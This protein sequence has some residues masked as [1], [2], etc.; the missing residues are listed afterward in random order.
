MAWRRR[1]RAPAL[2]V[3]V[4]PTSALTALLLVAH[5]A[6]AMRRVLCILLI[7]VALVTPSAAKPRRQCRRACDEAIRRW[8]AAHGGKQQGNC[9]AH[10]R[11]QCRHHGP[12]VCLPTTTTLQ[13]TVTTTTT[14][15]STTLPQRGAI[16]PITNP[17][18]RCSSVARDHRHGQVAYRQ[19]AESR[20]R[21]RQSDQ[22]AG[23]RRGHRSGYRDGAG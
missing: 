10:I 14:T 19:G 21:N 16:P 12:Q 5:C 11:S 9:K 4:Q 6:A 17:A 3:Y 8:V 20:P 1:M 2:S 18:A 15:T 23:T 7:A 22:N 13:V